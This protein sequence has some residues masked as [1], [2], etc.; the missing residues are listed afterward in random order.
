MNESAKV[1]S[2]HLQR[3]AYLYVR[4]SSIRQVQENRESAVRQYD[5]RRRALALGWPPDRIVVVDEDQGLS[6]ATSAGRD[7]FQ[8]LVA[9]VGLGRVG[10]VMGLEVSRLARS[11][12]DWHRLLEICALADALILDEDGLYD[13]G[14]FNDRLLL[15]LKGAMSEAELHVLRARLI[16]GQISKARRGELWV[17]APIGYV[18]DG[19]KGLIF[20]PDV[21][22]RGSV[23]ML[24]EEFRRLGSAEAVVRRFRQQGLRWPKRLAAGPRSGEV[25][26]DELV[27]SRILGILHNP[28]YA[29]AYVYGR[30]RQRKQGGRVKYRRLPKDQ[31]KVFIPDAHPGYISWETFEANQARLLDNANGYGPDRRKSP[32]REG[33]ALLQGLVVCGACGRRMTVRYHVRRGH[34]IPDYLCQRLGIQTAQAACQSIPGSGLDEAIAQLLLEAVTPAALEVALEVFEELRTRRAD[35]DR[36]RRSQIERARHEAELAQRHYLLVRP[37]NRLVADALER[38][39]NERLV[40]LDR[41]QE[42][43][44][45]SGKDGAGDLNPEARRHI[46]ALSSDLPRVWKD[47][48]TSARDRKRMLRLLVED[49]TLL[50]DRKVIRIAIRWKGGATTKLERPVPLG[51][52]EL[53]RTPADIVEQVRALATRQ[54]DLEIARTLN[55]RWLR[56]GRGGRFTPRIVKKIRAAYAIDSLRDSLRKQ[57]WLTGKEMAARLGVHRQTAKRH[58]DAGTLEARRVN[59]K[60]EVLY[61]PFTGPLPQGEPGGRSKDSRRSSKVCVETDQ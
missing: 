1:R 23:G 21:Q 45:Q 10:L 59:D 53:F 47:P 9:D 54:T 56:S 39:W 34:P 11:S 58:A 4:Q 44:A 35:L 31:W 2:E 14:H 24:F 18:H 25:V 22:I 5:L 50:R 29:G 57:G 52:G 30:S 48:R 26:W 6:G 32:P 46:L 19:R 43:Y 12:S 55:G 8:R 16:G 60:N 33:A 38:Q 42:E 7:G 28:R 27:H 20:D 49:V 17:R 13:P 41:L 51:G 37:E 61:A 15:G 40:E 3:Q 36:L